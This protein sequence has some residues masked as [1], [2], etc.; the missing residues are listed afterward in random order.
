MLDVQTPF[1]SVAEDAASRL[2]RAA[3][4]RCLP[5]LTGLQREAVMLAYCGG[6]T[7]RELATDLGVAV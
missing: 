2:D 7:Y 1:D 3:V 6:R 5:A 4:R